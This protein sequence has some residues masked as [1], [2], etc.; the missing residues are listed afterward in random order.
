[1]AD[2]RI[3]FT[4]EINDKGKVKVDGLTKSFV[5]LDNAVN[6][7]SADLKAQQSALAGSNAK[8]KNTISDAGLAGATLT[9]LGRTISDSN[10][11]IRGMANNLSQLSTLFITLVSKEGEG[12]KGFVGAL[13]RLKNQLFGPL[14]IILAF[15]TIVALIER[16]AINQERAAS[17]TKELQDSF[18][19]Q[20]KVLLLLT[21][22]ITRYDGESNK[23]LITGKAFRE[24]VSLLVKESKEFKN[25]FENLT[26]FSEENV[27][28]LLKDYIR[29]LELED[30]R[31]DLMAEVNKLSEEEDASSEKILIKSRELK[32]ILI[33]LHPLQERFGLSTSK[34]AEEVGAMADDMSKL[35]EEIFKIYSFE[36]FDPNQPHF[37]TE[38]MEYLAQIQADL[39]TLT[40]TVFGLTADQRQKELAAL[41]ARF[42]DATRETKLY[43][44]AVRLINEKYDKIERERREREHRAEQQAKFNHL[45]TM[46][47]GVADFFQASA[48]LNEQNKALARSA[49]IAS[50]AAASVGVWQSYHS[51][52]ASPK[53]FLATAGAV[54]AQLA[55]VAQT[56]SALK[57]LNS[58]S[59]VGQAGGAG[60]GSSQ[61]PVF[62]VVGQSNVN[63]IGRSI[64][65]ARSQPIHTYVLANEVTSQQ[66]LDNKIIQSATLG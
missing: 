55:I 2:N 33:A 41:R 42:N 49:I 40:A 5:S 1:M 45:S 22:N 31:K 9:E 59:P 48:E 37:I 61:A 30:E 3:Q 64:A 32:D 62:N 4:F 25:A 39:P 54:A 34:S 15:Q 26:D 7:V 43:K 29:M 38:F 63:Q 46:L 17:A 50:S 14:G 60:A 18:S 27:R 47:K 35:T 65:E 12:V 57:S 58:G 11:G 8:L 66:E 6:K 13:T 36:T 23:A 52:E 24:E 56:A 10:Y 44:E 28:A 16:Y 21:K 51:I 20:R 19:E 53:G